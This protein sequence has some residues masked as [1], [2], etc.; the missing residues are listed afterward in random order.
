MLL[1]CWW[2][3][4]KKY[5]INL[6]ERG[7]G[8]F[9]TFSRETSKGNGD[10][11]CPEIRVYSELI[12]RNLKKVWGREETTLEKDNYGKSDQWEKIY[13]PVWLKTGSDLG[14]CTSIA[15]DIF[16]GEIPRFH[17]SSTL[18]VC[19]FLTTSSNGFNYYWVFSFNSKRDKLIIIALDKGLSFFFFY[20]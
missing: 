5:T 17:E 19:G 1:W 15:F 8:Y 20:K 11:E 16:C 2:K 12:I 10:V 4:G 18:I 6:D 13:T 7:S 9:E 14:P 3:N